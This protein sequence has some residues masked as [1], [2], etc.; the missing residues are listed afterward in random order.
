LKNKLPEMSDEQALELLGTDGMLVKRPIIVSANNVLVGFTPK[1][2][3]TALIS[4]VDS[5]Q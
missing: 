1:A 5:I 3:E 4:T 2:W